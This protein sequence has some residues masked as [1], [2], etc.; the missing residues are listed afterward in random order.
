MGWILYDNFKSDSNLNYHPPL[1]YIHFLQFSFCTA[2]YFIN[3]LN[4]LFLSRGG[5]IGRRAG[6]KIRDPS[7]CV[8]SIP[9]LGT[10]IIIKSLQEIEGFYYGILL[11]MYLSI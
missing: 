2:F 10:K 7:G 11:N 4:T 9:S 5:E 8:G 6:F 1:K 3:K